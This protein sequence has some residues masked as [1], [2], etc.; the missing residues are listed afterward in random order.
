MLLTSVWRVAKWKPS[1][2][3]AL[4]GAFAIFFATVIVSRPGTLILSNAAV[5]GLSVGLSLVLGR[6]LKSFG[7]LV[8]F[9]IV[10]SVVDIVSFGGGLTKRI[11]TDFEA[12]TSDLLRYLAIAIRLEGGLQPLVGIGDLCIMGALFIGLTRLHGRPVRAGAVLLAGL[13]AAVSVG[14]LVGGAPGLP[15]LAAVAVFDGWLALR[16]TETHTHC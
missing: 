10:I 11:I 2:Q 9:A 3:W 15:F 12:G 14:I 1:T 13:S 4:T 8:A 16:G 6:T 7:A 5:L